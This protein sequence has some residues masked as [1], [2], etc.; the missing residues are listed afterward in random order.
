MQHF[1]IKQLSD[2]YITCKTIKAR[3]AVNEAMNELSEAISMNR[4]HE[5][6]INEYN[7]EIAYGTYVLTYWLF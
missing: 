5:L 6:T 4:K 2:K 3:E 1:E 7:I